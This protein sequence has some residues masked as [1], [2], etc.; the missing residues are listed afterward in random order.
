MSKLSKQ[1]IK[2]KDVNII[3]SRINNNDLS[4]DDD[5]AVDWDKFTLKQ[6]VRIDNAIIKRNKRLK[7]M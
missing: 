2:D 7:V 4:V 6:Q 5:I 3:I 1:M